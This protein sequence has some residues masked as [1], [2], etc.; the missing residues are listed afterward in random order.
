MSSSILSNKEKLSS[1]SFV[2]KLNI[3]SSPLVV[4]IIF[5][6]DIF[7]IL[8]FKFKLPPIKEKSNSI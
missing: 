4:L 5:I 2:N 7:N 1:T 3:S 6:V 8:L